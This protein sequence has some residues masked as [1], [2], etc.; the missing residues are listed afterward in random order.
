[1][2]AGETIPASSQKRSVRVV[3]PKDAVGPIGASGGGIVAPGW[4]LA[5]EQSIERAVGDLA[6]DDPAFAQMALGRE[7]QALQG[8]RRA[9]VARVDVGFQPPQ[10]QRAEGVAFI[11]VTLTFTQND[12][13]TFTNAVAVVPAA[14][15]LKVTLKL[16]V[17][18]PTP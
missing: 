3:T 1:M 16:F 12:G 7:A 4:P 5:G 8:S 10:R 14:G 13:S 18:Q 15:A 17:V 6:G 2:R 11:Q 9:L